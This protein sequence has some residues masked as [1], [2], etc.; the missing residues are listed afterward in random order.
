MTIKMINIMLPHLGL[1][2]FKMSNFFEKLAG[3]YLTR[4]LDD[5]SSIAVAIHVVSN[6]VNDLRVQAGVQY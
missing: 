5:F 4:F 2:L 1:K 3:Y 6:P